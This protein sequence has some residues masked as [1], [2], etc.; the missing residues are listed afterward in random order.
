VPRPILRALLALALATPIPACVAQTPNVREPDP[1]PIPREF[2]GAWVAAVANIDWPSRPG[3][4]TWQQQAE[5]VAIL[6]RARQMRLNAIVFH[7]RPAAD[8]LYASTREPWSS[9][10]SGRQGL[11]PEPIWDP[12]AF[13]IEKAHE[14]G[15]ELHAWFNPFRAFH[16]SGRSGDTATTH[17]VRQQ[18]QLVRRYG[19]HW[20]MDPG[21]PRVREHSLEVI[22]DVVRRYDIDAVHLDDYFYPYRERDARGEIPFP[23]DETYARYRAG[24]GRLGR[25]DWRRNNVDEFLRVLY[26][27]VRNEKSHVRVGISPFGIWRP[28]NPPGVT[29]LDAYQSIY[30]DSRKWLRN[31]WLDYLAPQL[32]WRIDSPQSFPVLLRWWVGENV[33]GRHIWPGLFTSRVAAPQVRPTDYSAVEIAE[34][35]RHSRQVPGSSGHIH[36]SM[37]HLMADPSPDALAQRLVE[38]YTQQALVPAT[39]WLG[40]TP[41]VPPAVEV[42]RDTA[43]G[44]RFV[45]LRSGTA[46]RPWLWTVQVRRGTTWSTQILPG[47]QLRH[48]LTRSAAEPMPDAVVISAVDRLGNQSQLVRLRW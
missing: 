47:H 28:Q 5:L 48:T 19:G 15:L 2:R 9:F 45:L 21:D 43:T 27:R 39:R 6:D 23:D 8:A 34:K 31:G 26:E 40:A 3:L 32:Y 36:F 7:V 1:P 33:H 29:G 12:L 44:G 24:G 35:I 22:L 16:P 20:W 30:A 41:P 17:I 42:A 25:D 46:P 10:L 18:R 38:V 4:S 14:R 13:A 11:A 37:R